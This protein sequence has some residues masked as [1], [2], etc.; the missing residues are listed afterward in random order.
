MGEGQD[1]TVQVDGKSMD[2]DGSNI[3]MKNMVRYSF[4]K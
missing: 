4:I 3:N 1:G 2:Q